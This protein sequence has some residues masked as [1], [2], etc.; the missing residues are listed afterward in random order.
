MLKEHPKGLLVAFFSNMG[1]RFG[2]YT[3][4]GIL[5]YF[6]QARYGL[7]ADNAGL[8]YSIFYASI[9]GLALVGGLIADRTRNYKGVINIGIITMFIGY[10][11]MA[12]PRMGLPITVLGLFTIAFGNGLFKGNLQAVV[13]QMY[14]EPKYS[15]LRDSAFTI[16][17]MGI[18]IG[19]FFAPTAARAIRNWYLKFNGLGSDSGLPSLC[20]Q[21]LGG[22]LT[23]TANFEQLANIANGG[24]PVTDLTA[25]ANKYINVFSTGYNFAFGIAAV[26]M[27]ISLI[28]YKIWNSKL[29]DVRKQKE[30]AA[31]R[32]EP[33]VK[34]PLM[35]KEVEK[36]RLIAL[37][38]VFLVVI[39][40]WMS[41]HQNGLTMS[42]F[43]RD[44]T[45]K[46]VDTISYVFFDII[47]FLGIIGV[48]IGLVLLLKKNSAK[49]KG[50]GALL[51]VVCGCLTYY[52]YQGFA[53]NN[54]IEPE[55]FQHF[56]PIFIVFLTPIV[57]A[58]FAFLRKRD[59]EPTTPKK[60]GIGMILAAVAFALLLI[61][62][63]KL[64]SP[65]SLNQGPSPERV[66]HFW[67]IGTYF[68]ITIAELF[69]SPMG[70]SFVSKVAPPRLQGLAQGGWLAATAI[71]NQLLFV[72]T[73]LWSRVELWQVWG[74]FILCCLASATFI[75]SVL[76]KLEKAAA[77]K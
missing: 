30:E 1:E 54:T 47:S 22:T 62:S 2:F 16:F 71:G 23:D 33:E 38:L 49:V 9:Y 57:L 17:Y 40:F 51:V 43:A 10:I 65:V 28:V 12:V 56:N 25:F 7:A 26:A 61:G 39:F 73:V 76:K 50:I 53:Q 66:S 69:L 27:L 55:L 35:S 15:K 72:G 8:I 5:V 48:V 13:G 63:L 46:A 60:I 32:G 29:P 42:L 45:V 24:A 21:Y 11:L 31:K 36:Q 52:K 77:S 18:N 68:I 67:L 14:D 75:F 58:F 6:L 64:S 70:I 37:G 3:M 41:F 74:I 59:K 34:V 20:H 19:A 44:Y 4:M